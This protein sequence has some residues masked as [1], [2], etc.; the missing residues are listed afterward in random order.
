M[1]YLEKKT[2]EPK[3]YDSIFIGDEVSKPPYF[4]FPREWFN[5]TDLDES[6]VINVIR[7]VCVQKGWIKEEEVTAKELIE[8]FKIRRTYCESDSI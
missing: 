8:K 4:G 1:D 5:G 7:P 3:N 6:K 2:Q